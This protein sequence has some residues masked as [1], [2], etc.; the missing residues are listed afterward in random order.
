MSTTEAA[1]KR[2]WVDYEGRSFA[3]VSNSELNL[4]LE[5]RYSN[6]TKNATNWAVKTFKGM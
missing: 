1:N 6:A 4:L 3:A 5:N 2:Q